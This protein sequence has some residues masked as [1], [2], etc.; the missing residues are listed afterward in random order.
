MPPRTASSGCWRWAPK[1]TSPSLSARKL[2]APNWSALWGYLVTD[3]TIHTALSSA[4][5]EV[6]DCMFF[7]EV[8]G[9][10]AEPLP[11]AE[12]VTVQVS[13]EGD[14]PGY[15][16]MRIARP[17]ANA[18]A[19]DFLGEDLELLS[20]RQ[21]TDVTLELANMIRSEEPHV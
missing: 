8:L 10:I 1:P 16:Q 2:C 20:D 12:S 11:Q 3:T 18:V 13:F 19:A 21:S 7:L 4:V 14:P 9:E 6:L 17:A 5:A 15:F